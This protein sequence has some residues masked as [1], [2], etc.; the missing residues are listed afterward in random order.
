MPRFCANLAHLF[1]EHDVLDR[2]M[3]A[4]KAGFSAVEITFPYGVEA[5]E[6]ARAREQAGVEWVL[7]NLPPGGNEGDIGLAALPGREQEF[8]EGV[9]T[10]QRYA[11][12]LGAGRINA[13]VGIVPPDVER[14]RSEA[15]LAE[16]LNYAAGEME[17]VGVAV[18]V[19][20][21]NGIDRPGFALQ[22]VAHGVRAIDRVDHPNLAIEADIYHMG[23]MGEDLLGTFR[24][25]IDRI[26]HIQIAD[27]P[28]RGEPGS[29]ELDFAT[30]FAT[31]DELGYDGWIS[32][33]YHPTGRTEDCLAWFEPYRQS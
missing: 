21:I 31:I 10:A 7:F 33:E 20:P 28:G 23:R 24:Q 26:G 8:R 3:A 22:T 32:A 6:L 14:E 19:E 30:L 11:E 29:G 9:A 5:A 2:C 16:N 17:K 1:L 15:V 27:L 18:M 13:L 25:Y 12:A 4:H